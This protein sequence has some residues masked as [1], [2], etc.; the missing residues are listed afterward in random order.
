MALQLG[1]PKMP[2]SKPRKKRRSGR[3]SSRC[4]GRAPDHEKSVGDAGIRGIDAERCCEG[5]EMILLFH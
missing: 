1:K 4:R 5:N 3:N 2:A